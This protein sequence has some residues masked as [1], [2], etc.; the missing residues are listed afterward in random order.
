MEKVPEKLFKDSPEQQGVYF[1]PQTGVAI[2]FKY[3]ISEGQRIRLNKEELE[4][5]T[6]ERG[7]KARMPHYLLS[8]K[9]YLEAQ[10]FIVED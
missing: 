10:K 6:T 5:V 1:D 4:R 9:R 2:T 8:I 3:S 7:E